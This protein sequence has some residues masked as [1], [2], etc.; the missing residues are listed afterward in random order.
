MDNR[1]TGVLESA[2]PATVDFFEVDCLLLRFDEVDLDDDDD[3]ECDTGC[4]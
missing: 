2:F 4:S 1:G 3:D